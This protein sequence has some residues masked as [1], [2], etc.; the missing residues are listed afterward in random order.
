MDLWCIYLLLGTIFGS[1]FIFRSILIFGAANCG[2]QLDLGTS[3]FGGN[4]WWKQIVLGC[5]GTFGRYHFQTQ[6]HITSLVYIPDL[7]IH[8]LH[9]QYTPIISALY[10]VGLYHNVCWFKSNWPFCHTKALQMTPWY[11]LAIN[12]TVCWMENDPFIEH[13]RWNSIYIYIQEFVIWNNCPSVE[14]SVEDLPIQNSYVK[15]SP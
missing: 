7:K 3:L 14:F 10:P 8:W 9:L 15:Y 5:F 12:S 6:P 2:Y 1:A 11:P 13:C 4:T